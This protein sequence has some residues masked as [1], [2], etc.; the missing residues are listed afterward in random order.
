MGTTAGP[1][2]FSNPSLS[3]L[4]P[5]IIGVIVTFGSVGACTGANVLF[6]LQ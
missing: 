6:G 4:A 1:S 3:L 2:L 5:A